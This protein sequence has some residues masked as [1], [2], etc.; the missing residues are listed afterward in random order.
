MLMK[1]AIRKFNE[2]DYEPLCCLLSDPKVMLY[3]EP[4]YSKEQTKVFLQA[5]LS[6]H[7][8]VYTVELDGCFIVCE[9]LRI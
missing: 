2:S 7:P 1:P 9:E 5:A 6:D 3:L 8:P 4:P